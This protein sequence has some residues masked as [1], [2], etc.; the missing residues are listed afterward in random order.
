MANMNNNLTLEINPNHPLMVK[1]NQTR[2]QNIG[3]AAMLAKQILDNTLLSAGLMDNQKN[4]IARVNK[5]MMSVMGDSTAVN[6]D[7]P[8]PVTIADLERDQEDD[9]DVQKMLDELQSE[10]DDE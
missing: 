7:E 4:Y 9:Q 3:L 2:R 10:S 5:L 8:K 1:L 6:Y